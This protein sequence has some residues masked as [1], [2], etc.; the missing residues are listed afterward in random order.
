[1]SSRYIDALTFGHLTLYEW[2]AANM[3]ATCLML[4]MGGS[5]VNIF[6]YFTGLEGALDVWVFDLL[7]LLLSLLFEISR[8]DLSILAGKQRLLCIHLPVTEA[9]RWLLDLR[10]LILRNLTISTL[11]LL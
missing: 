1:M 2:R 6:G 8:S 11:F 7:R 3:I 9:S 10:S 5:P 4:D